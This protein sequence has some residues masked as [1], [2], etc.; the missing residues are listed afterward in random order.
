MVNVAFVTT[1]PLARRQGFA[2]AKFGSLWWQVPARQFS[3]TRDVSQ[4]HSLSRTERDIFGCNPFCSKLAYNDTSDNSQRRLRSWVYMAHVVWVPDDTLVL[5]AMRHVEEYTCWARN[6][7]SEW[8]QS[9]AP[10]H[11]NDVRVKGGRDV[12]GTFLAKWGCMAIWRTQYRRH[13][14]AYKQKN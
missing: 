6:T 2:Q 3:A 1:S 9:E 5:E 8:D 12:E 14:R 13:V 10:V 11:W 7:G 4:I